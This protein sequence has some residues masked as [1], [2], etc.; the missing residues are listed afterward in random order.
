M[1]RL[2]E[3]ATQMCLHRVSR[4]SM[5]VSAIHRLWLSLMALLKSP[6]GGAC[7]ALLRIEGVIMMAGRQVDGLH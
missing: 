6:A 1:V 4:M 2:L 7:D 5:A 3:N